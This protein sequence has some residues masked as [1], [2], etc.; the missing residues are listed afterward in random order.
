MLTR[1]V[2]IV[3]RHLIACFCFKANVNE[4]GKY[5]ICGSENGRFYLWN[6]NYQVEKGF[7]LSRYS[8]ISYIHRLS[9]LLITFIDR[10]LSRHNK[11]T[12][13]TYEYVDCTGD[14][15]VAVTSSIFAPSNTVY[16]SLLI[17]NHL[18]GNCRRLLTC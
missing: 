11:W 4:D 6:I 2:V 16:H 5:M 15:D 9:R 12:N 17:S 8:F 1:T 3:I 10:M 13:Q 7:K 18:T 14:E